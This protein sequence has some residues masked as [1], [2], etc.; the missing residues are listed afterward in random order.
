M[1]KGRMLWAWQGWVMLEG[2]RWSFLCRDPLPCPHA[3]QLWPQGRNNPE[4]QWRKSILALSFLFFFLFLLV[5]AV[6]REGERAGLVV[7][8]MGSSRRQGLL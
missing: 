7:V 5:A 4:G 6:W 1:F 8:L 3:A 2:H